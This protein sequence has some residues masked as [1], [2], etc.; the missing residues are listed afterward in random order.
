MAWGRLCGVAGIDE[1]GDNRDMPFVSLEREIGC[2]TG[3]HWKLRPWRAV[4]KDKDHGWSP[5]LWVLYLGFF[6]IDPILSHASAKLWL[7]D[8][9]G[10]AVFLVLYLGIFWIE[11]PLSLVHIAGMVLLGILFQRTNSGACTFFIFAAAMLPFSVKTQKAAVIGLLTIG[12]IG[13]INVLLL[14]HMN[15]WLLF[16]ASLFPMVIGAGN[17]FFAERNRMNRKLRRPTKRSNTWPRWPNANALRATC[18]T[19]WDTRCR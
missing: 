13:A 18:M 16:D 15:G 19:S 6:F 7:Y 2:G 5:L 17:I 3:S 4:F 11:N 1:Q 10:A 9:L 8:A 12:S 14:P